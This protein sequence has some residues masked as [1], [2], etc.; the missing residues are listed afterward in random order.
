MYSYTKSHGRRSRRVRPESFDVTS[1]GGTAGADPATPGA[2]NSGLD[3]NS[4]SR[5]DTRTA[6]PDIPPGRTVTP[7]EIADL[8]E[9]ALGGLGSPDSG[10][11]LPHAI[12]SSSSESGT[13]D[14]SSHESV[15]EKPVLENPNREG[16]KR[17][18]MEGLISDDGFVR[19]GDERWETEPKRAL[20]TEQG[21]RSTPPP[22]GRKRTRISVSLVHPCTVYRLGMH[23]AWS[24]STVVLAHEVVATWAELGTAGSASAARVG[25]FGMASA[26][27]V[28]VLMSELS[29]VVVRHP[30]TRWVLL[31]SQLPEPCHCEAAMVGAK[32]Y[33]DE[34]LNAD[35]FEEMIRAVDAGH[36]FG[37][38]V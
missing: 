19:C 7:L 8:R 13:H 26:T 2:A 27:P 21:S 28:S 32:G 25:L 14:F 9:F 5:A 3:K 4:V 34:A 23:Y 38:P 36:T 15:S 6:R 24:T 30:F 10:H 12:E 22:K 17:D 16:K 37:L 33:L 11:A 1:G 31:A 18:P 29:Q 20:S 35:Q